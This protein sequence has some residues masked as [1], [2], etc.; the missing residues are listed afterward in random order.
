MDQLELTVL[1]W[2]TFVSIEIKSATISCQNCHLSVHTWQEQHSSSS[3]TQTSHPGVLT[4]TAAFHRSSSAP[5][6]GRRPGD[7]WNARRGAS[8]HGGDLSDMLIL[9]ARELLLQLKGLMRWAD[10]RVK[11]R[12]RALVWYHYRYN[13]MTFMESNLFTGIWWESKE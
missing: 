12:E 6:Q 5:K 4:C 13:K 7:S 2:A 9:T 8:S 11:H 10:A 1:S 3:P